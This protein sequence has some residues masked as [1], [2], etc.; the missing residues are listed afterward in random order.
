MRPW[1]ACSCR[2][3][4]HPPISTPRA[5]RPSVRRR[6]TN[7]SPRSSAPGQILHVEVRLPDGRVVAADDPAARGATAPASPDF[8]TALGRPDGDRRDRRDRPERGGRHALPTTHVVREYF[9]VDHGRHGP[10]GRRRV[11]RR[12]TD[13]GHARGRP[14]QPGPRH[15]LG[16]ARRRRG[17]LPRLP[18]RAGPDQPPDGRARRCARA[19]PVDRDA[20][21]RRARQPRRGVA[22]ARAQGRRGPRR[23]THRHRQLPPAQRELRPRRRRSGAQDGLRDAPTVAAGRRRVRAVRARTSCW[24]S[25]RPARSPR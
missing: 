9:P 11:A 17:P 6:W 8:A 14:P 5:S 19:R 23:R 16:R 15:G 12:G 22:R 13:R 18:L 24:S 10:R 1:S 20:Q 2:A 4:C 3:T 25:R 7:A 21:P